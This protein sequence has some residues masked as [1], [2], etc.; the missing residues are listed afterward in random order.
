[1][2]HP[3]WA[4]RCN[5]KSVRIRTESNLSTVISRHM[6]S[7]SPLAGNP[8]TRPTRAEGHTASRMAHM[9]DR[10]RLTPL[11]DRP[12]GL[13]HTRCEPCHPQH[14]L[15]HER[16]QGW[17]WDMPM[18]AALSKPPIQPDNTIV[19]IITFYEQSIPQPPADER[20]RIIDVTA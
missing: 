13:G 14:L 11:P 5:D 16:P 10:M 19:R 2:T 9:E 18:P 6:A 20:E 1:M 3:G 7:S 12:R 8:A 15:M 17:P 4:D